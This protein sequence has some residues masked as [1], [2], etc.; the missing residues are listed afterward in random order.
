MTLGCNIP[1]PFLGL[2]KSIYMRAGFF[3]EGQEQMRKALYG[4]GGFVNGQQYD[5]GSPGLIETANMMAMGDATN[6]KV[7]AA[8]ADEQTKESSGGAKASQKA[9]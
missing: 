3:P 5:F 2:L 1:P 4:P 6:Y 9:S 7:T 8:E